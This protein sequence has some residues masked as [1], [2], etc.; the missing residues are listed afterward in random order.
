MTAA[1]QRTIYVNDDD[2][3]RVQDLADHLGT[4][5]S[6]AIRVAV[7]EAAERRGITYDD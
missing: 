6:E 4:S 1:P 5:Y 2:W 3:Q 7:R